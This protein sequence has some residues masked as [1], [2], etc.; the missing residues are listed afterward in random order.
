MF[1]LYRKLGRP[2]KEVNASNVK[3][4]PKATAR[5]AQPRIRKPRRQIN[6]AVTNEFRERHLVCNEHNTI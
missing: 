5:N 2:R 4:T 3:K 6:E 1:S